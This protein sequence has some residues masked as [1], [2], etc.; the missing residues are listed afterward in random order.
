MISNHHRVSTGFLYWNAPFIEDIKEVGKNC[1]I[2]TMSL[3]IGWKKCE[4]QTFAHGILVGWLI[5]SIYG[6][7]TFNFLQIQLIIHCCSAAID[8]G[9]NGK[10]VKIVSIADADK[11]QYD[12][13]GL[14]QG[15]Y[16]YGAEIDEN[17]QFNHQT[18][19]PDGITY[20]CYGYL[21][22]EGK[23]QSKH[24]IADARGFRLLTSLD[25][26]DVYPIAS[27]SK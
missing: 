13:R 14:D 4:K 3:N 23:I 5:S 15:A 21:D 11:T 27:K 6:K 25:L 1:L 24:Y 22:D 20:G 16:N 7:V 10:G 26:V 8:E 2:K 19:A 9:F 17:V 12:E 18:R